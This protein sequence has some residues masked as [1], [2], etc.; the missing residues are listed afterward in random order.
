MSAGTKS[1]GQVSSRCGGG[2]PRFFPFYL[3]SCRSRNL[4]KTN[5]VGIG[6][7]ALLS[8]CFSGSRSSLFL[9]AQFDLGAQ[10]KSR[11]HHATFLSQVQWF[12]FPRVSSA[13]RRRYS[14]A[15]RAAQ[16]AQLWLA[17]KLVSCA[18]DGG[19]SDWKLPASGLKFCQ[20]GTPEPLGVPNL[21]KLVQ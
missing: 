21:A 5:S 17:M 2:S 20:T 16:K 15:R 4:E 6:S 7:F 19:M 18:G 3:V 9:S 1:P 8:L 12:A 11:F 10:Y 13:R 14:A